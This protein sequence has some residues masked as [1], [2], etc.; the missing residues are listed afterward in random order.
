MLES[1][2]VSAAIRANSLCRYRWKSRQIQVETTFMAS[3]TAVPLSGLM[4]LENDAG[5]WLCSNVSAHTSGWCMA[6][7]EQSLCR[8]SRQHPWGRMALCQG[9]CLIGWWLR[10]GKL[11]VVVC[12]TVGLNGITQITYGSSPL[13][14]WCQSTE[15]LPCLSAWKAGG[16]ISVITLRTTYFCAQ[17]KKQEDACLEGQEQ[18]S[19]ENRR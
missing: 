15:C 3:H 7:T 9:W 2:W 16:K 11:W 18:V 12:L 13:F 1:L 8:A 19:S 6:A 14:V 17:L 10:W 4:Q 5:R